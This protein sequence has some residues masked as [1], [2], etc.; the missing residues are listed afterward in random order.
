M[1]NRW[2]IAIHLAQSSID[3]TLSGKGT[4]ESDSDHNSVDLLGQETLAN[5]HGSLS[6]SVCS[7]WQYVIFPFLV[8]DELSTIAS[9]YRRIVRHICRGQANN[10]SHH[11]HRTIEKWSWLFF[12][13]CRRYWA[14]GQHWKA[15]KLTELRNKSRV[16][17]S[18]RSKTRVFFTRCSFSCILPLFFFY[19]DV[20][21]FTISGRFCEVSRVCRSTAH[22]IYIWA[23][24]N[25]VSSWWNRFLSLVFL[26][27]VCTEML[28]STFSLNIYIVQQSS[29]MFRKLDR[30]SLICMPCE[31][32]ADGDFPA[33]ERDI[34][35]TNLSQRRKICQGHRSPCRDYKY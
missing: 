28:K 32:S 15:S 33:N 21:V 24:Q 5:S 22:C 23:S 8:S 34:E 18:I 20:T 30:N 14:L 13:Q 16:L 9:N 10:W 2:I 19:C 17:W 12:S 4:S 31:V 11:A 1:H 35:A 25:D 27:E 6:F 29:R 7:Y 3:L 26:M